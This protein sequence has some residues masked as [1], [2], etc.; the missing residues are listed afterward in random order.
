MCIGDGDSTL[1]ETW[2]MDKCVGDGRGENGWQSGVECCSIMKGILDILLKQMVPK[3]R[4]KKDEEEA[5][6]RG[7]EE[8]KIKIAEIQKK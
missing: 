2:C 5:G 8:E 6:K 1:G 4:F 3:R 7:G